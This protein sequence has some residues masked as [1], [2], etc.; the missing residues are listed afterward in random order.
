ML[1]GI[2]QLAGGLFSGAGN[3]KANE[4]NKGKKKELGYLLENLSSYADPIRD[5]LLTGLAPNGF[6]R[7]VMATPGIAAANASAGKATEKARAGAWRTGGRS[8]GRF[9][10]SLQDAED[11]RMIGTASALN[12]ADLGATQQL[13]RIRA[14]M[15]GAK[16]AFPV[17]VATNP[18]LGIAQGFNEIGSLAQQ[19]NQL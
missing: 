9:L 6:L 3:V 15:L 16:N 5:S 7:G 14:A 13:S 2:M 10:R 12:A 17:T 8:S 19:P 4:A 18:Y 11:A 1:G